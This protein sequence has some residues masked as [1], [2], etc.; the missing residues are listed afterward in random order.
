MNR[1]RPFKEEA[2]PYLLLLPVFIYYIVFWVRPV[3]MAFF[4]AFTDKANDPTFSNFVRLFAQK[5]IQLALLN[6]SVFVVVSLVIQFFLSICI[7]VA[8]NKKF[9]FSGLVLFIFLIPMAL[10]PSAVGILWKSGMYR[11]GWLNSFLYT[12][13]LASR[14]GLIDWIS[15]RGMKAVLLLVLIDTWTVLPSITIIILA[16]LQ[17]LNREFEEAGLVFGANRFQVVKDIVVPIMKP[18]IV[19]AMV[20]RMIAAIQVWMIAVMIY[21][22]NV[23][24]FLVERITYNLDAVTFGAFARKDAYALSVMVLVIVLVTST[25]Y[26][27][28]NSSGRR[29]YSQR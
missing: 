12:V 28:F 2:L 16:G 19:T 4:Q 10:P 13:G 21:G 26:L 7:A 3:Y 11:F 14:E 29:R 25:G 18:S 20:I 8:L 6:T 15:F 1:K 9:R 17:N 23:T 22:Y 24:P 27:Y 5:D